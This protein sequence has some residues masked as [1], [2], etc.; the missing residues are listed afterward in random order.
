MPQ[1]EIESIGSLSLIL[2]KRCRHSIPP[3]QL[4]LVVVRF[5]LRSATHALFVVAYC[6][7][8]KLLHQAIK[9]GAKALSRQYQQ[10]ID[11]LLPQY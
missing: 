10:I 5:T 7:N 8:I 6:G 3:L 9:Q 4:A 2:A 11:S 1:S